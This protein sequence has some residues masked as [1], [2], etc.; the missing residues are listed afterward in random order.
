MLTH[1][2]SHPWYVIGRIVCPSCH[3]NPT[4]C[5]RNL[6]INDVI[7]SDT[8]QTRC[9]EEDDVRDWVYGPIQTP[10]EEERR[11]DRD[12]NSQ[13]IRVALPTS[14]GDIP[15]GE[16]ERATERRADHSSHQREYRITAE[17]G[18]GEL[19]HEPATL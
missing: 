11:G 18:E 8:Y 12:H 16:A 15:Q 3:E 10:E 7:A 19:A 1:A 6:A 5:R 2:T 13:P 4:T 9:H 14:S 17:A